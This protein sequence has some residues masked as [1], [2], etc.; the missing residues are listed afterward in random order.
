MARRTRKAILAELD[1]PL[2]P[3]A[4][5]LAV[6]DQ[7]AVHQYETKARTRAALKLAHRTL[8]ELLQHIEASA[9][10]EQLVSRATADSLHRHLRRS[11][12]LDKP[13]RFPSLPRP[14]PP[15][16]P[17]TPPAVTAA[18]MNPPPTAMDAGRA[19]ELF[20]AEGLEFDQHAEGLE[21]DQHERG[22]AR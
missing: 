20:G 4:D 9:R 3:V 18:A 1:A 5:T 7:L 17:S 8:G 22:G 21:F 2:P 10:H 13:K 19:A 12:E 6:L 16:P 15:A 11:L 14:R